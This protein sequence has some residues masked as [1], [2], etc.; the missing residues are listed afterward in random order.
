MKNLVFQYYIPYE[1]NDAHMGGIEM[2]VWAEFGSKSAQKYARACKA[3]YIL[4]HERYFKHLDPRLDALRVIYDPYFD[5]FDKVLS[6]DLDILLKIL[7]A[8]IL[9]LRF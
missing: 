7:S 9:T 8:I 6:I 2:P 4:S 5:Q 3:D 1:A